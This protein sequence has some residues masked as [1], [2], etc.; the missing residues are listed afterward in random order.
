MR[1]TR[2]ALVFISVLLC[3]TAA[4]CSP[5]PTGRLSNAEHSL[6]SAVRDGHTTE[7]SLSELVP[8]DWDAAYLFGPC[9]FPDR[10]RATLGFDWSGADTIENTAYCGDIDLVRYLIVVVSD[11]E[12]YGWLLVNG[13]R[14]APHA[15][16]R[17]DEPIVM[18]NHAVLRITRV[19]TR[20]LIEVAVP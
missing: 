1:N 8:G 15:V 19:G 10:I 9:E 2:Q 14:D 12:V 6:A 13:D 5:G 16:V 3:F 7:V 20:P 4:A 11:D 18:P 17:V